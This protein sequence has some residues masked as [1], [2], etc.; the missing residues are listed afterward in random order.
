MSLNK[1]K[2]FTCPKCKSKGELIMWDSINSAINPELKESILR[3]DLFN[4]KCKN[5][6]EEFEIIY[7]FLYHDPLNKLMIYLGDDGEEYSKLMDQMGKPFGYKL[8]NVGVMLD[9]VE[10]IKIFDA[11]LD[12]KAVEVSKQALLKS[13]RIKGELKF[14]K[15]DNEN[16]TFLSLNTSQLVQISRILYDSSVEFLKE[17]EEP[18][19]FLKINS[20]W[21]GRAK[22]YK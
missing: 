11:K 16:I 14:Y 6:N 12:D 4:W 22:N 21:A 7:S 19:G 9:L 3:G 5:C 8:R 18:E 15:I 1:Q 17:Y 13:G 10:K 20:N 2:V